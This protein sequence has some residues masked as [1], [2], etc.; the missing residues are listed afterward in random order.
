MALLFLGPASAAFAEKRVA[1]VIGVSAYDNAPA[2]KNP[3]RDAKAVAKAL[4]DVGFSDVREAYDLTKAEFDATLKRF[5]DAAAGA[6]WALVFFAGHG[7]SIGGETYLLPKD[8]VLARADH[9][10]DEAVSLARTRAKASGAKTLRLV[11][12]DSCRN[13]PFAARMKT[14]GSAKRAVN[15]RGLDRP[16]EPESGELIAYATRE[17]DVA[18]DG[19]GEHSP[20]TAA[21]LA[22]LRQ[23]GVEINFFFRRVR[24]AVLASTKRAQ[25][26]ALYMSLPADAFYFRPPVE[27]A[28][29]PV[30][31]PPVASGTQTAVI[32][33]P[34]LSFWPQP[35]ED[36][37][38]GVLVSVAMGDAKPCIKPGSGKSFKDC[39][40]CPEMV[41]APSGSFTM[42]SP[43]TEPGHSGY[44]GPQHEVRIAKPFA[45][46]KYAVTFA[47][48]DACMIDGGCDGY[49]PNGEGW[50][51][52][53]R[54]VINVS[55]KDAKAYVAWLSRKTGASYRLLSEAEREYVT[56]A[57][58]ATPFWWGSSITPEKSN[59]DG[60]YKYEG[61]GTEGVFRSQTVPV[62]SF[63]PNPWGLYQVH[64]N[65]WEWVEDCWN[66]TYDRAPTDGTAWTTGDCNSH[67]LR[68]GSWISYPRRLRSAHRNS[69][70]I[71]LNYVG[72]RVARTITP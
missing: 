55:W 16:P 24:S 60:H 3:V 45:V 41:I 21:F 29:Q 4:R 9:A 10:D 47:E 2:L 43:E 66:G 44:E 53:D 37:C 42:G 70:S 17:H 27:Q 28:Q 31:P 62:N 48:W 49:R 11:V 39:P 35:A 58:T 56:R 40:E 46:G 61:G 65:I 14:D 71:R 34:K 22:E 20:F 23:P 57:G 59:Y 12:L 54:P 69:S 64:G 8:A 63:E 25:D 51:R 15:P 5:G 7:I 19:E 13:N 18:D 26:P 36:A 50:G 52:G 67:V 6:D 30:A 72:L 38:D 33:P 1:L 68:G 32:A